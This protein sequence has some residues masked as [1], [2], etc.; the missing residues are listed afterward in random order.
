MLRDGLRLEAFK[1][2]QDMIQ[3]NFARLLTFIKLTVNIESGRRSN[4]DPQT[5]CDCKNNEHF[6]S[7]IKIRSVNNLN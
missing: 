6:P 4:I 5:L 3:A 1:V 2:L 7:A